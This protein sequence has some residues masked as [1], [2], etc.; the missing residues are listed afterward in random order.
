MPYC[1]RSRKTNERVTTRLLSPRPRYLERT[2]APLRRKSSGTAEPLP[3]DA[4]AEKPIA[5]GPRST[6]PHA[7][8]QSRSETRGRAARY[9]RFYALRD[10]EAGLTNGHG[11]GPVSRG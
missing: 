11:F 10:P 1:E 3:P 9:F 8:D 4:G 5:G 2:P 7:L 6:M